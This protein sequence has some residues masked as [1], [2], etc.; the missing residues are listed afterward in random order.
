M[1]EREVVVHSLWK[2]AVAAVEEQ[3]DEENGSGEQ[4]ELD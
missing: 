1:V 4:T 2:H 3:Y